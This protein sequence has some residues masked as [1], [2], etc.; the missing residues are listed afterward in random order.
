MQSLIEPQGEKL[1]YAILS[2][3]VTETLLVKEPAAP[4][5]TLLDAVYLG[6]GTAVQSITPWPE[7]ALPHTD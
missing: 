1:N 5:P 3:E 2:T 6:P 7:V 4:H